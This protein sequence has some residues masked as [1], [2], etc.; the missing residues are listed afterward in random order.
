MKQINERI[1]MSSRIS[2]KQQPFFTRR[3]EILSQ[4]RRT[5]G[6]RSE[7]E[8]REIKGFFRCA[9]LAFSIIYSFARGERRTHVQNKLLSRSSLGSGDRTVRRSFRSRHH[10]QFFHRLFSI[11]RMKK[12]RAIQGKS[13]YQTNYFS[14]TYRTSNV[15][16]PSHPH[17]VTT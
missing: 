15:D 3:R 7:G 1:R 14:Y 11:R 2:N 9:V 5:L 16:T 10:I 4:A 17:V 6:E 13:F 8:E 12:I